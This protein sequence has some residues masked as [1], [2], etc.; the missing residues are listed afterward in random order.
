MELSRF[1]LPVAGAGGQ[2]VE[3]HLEQV[4]VLTCDIGDLEYWAHP[5]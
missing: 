4:E 3:E 2:E 5:K 1:F